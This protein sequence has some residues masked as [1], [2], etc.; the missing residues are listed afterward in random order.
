MTWQGDPSKKL[1]DE[2]RSALQQKRNKLEAELKALKAR[3][4]A[5]KMPHHLR[6]FQEDLLAKAREMVKIDEKLGFPV[7]WFSGV[8]R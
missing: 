1:S 7:D 2:Q 4:P 8:R 6:H 5:G 3:G